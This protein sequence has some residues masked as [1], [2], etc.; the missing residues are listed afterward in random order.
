MA[1]HRFAAAAVLFTAAAAWPSIV[2]SLARW[3]MTPLE[4]ALQSAWCGL[5]P[6]QTLTFLGHCAICFAGVAVLAVAGALVLIADDRV[7][8]VRQTTEE[9]RHTT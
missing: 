3:T 5:P 2:Q 7:R 9:A 4:R 8:L 6:Q 1:L